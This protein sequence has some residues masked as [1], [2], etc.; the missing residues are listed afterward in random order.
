[1][2]DS[3]I[4]TRIRLALQSPDTFRIGRDFLIAQTLRRLP[5]KLRRRI[6]AGQEH[7]CPVCESSLRSFITLHRAY[8]LLCPVCWSFQR[9]RFIWI[10]FQNWLQPK[11]PS[12][13]PWKMLHIAPEPSLTRRFTA[14]PNVEYISA[15]LYDP[16]A[17][18]RMDICNI[19]YPERTFGLIYCSH[20]LEHV[21]D[22]R[23]AL[24]EFH[25]VLQD[26]GKAIIVIPITS[27][28]TYEDPT[29]T[30][31]QERER[32]FGQHDHVRVYGWDAVERMEAAGFRVTPVRRADLVSDAAVERLGLTE[33]ETV[34][35]L[36]KIADLR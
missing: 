10:F 30:S 24:A 19:Q 35:V 36:D 1:M 27:S 15:D 23:K 11:L 33:D 12:A 28:Q 18:V 32:V 13:T 22:D 9:H 20:V 6:F 14:L 21:P 4:S 31:P 5:T 26:D 16:K 3:D 17:M 8:N 2:V 25:R 29:I 34:F 7:F